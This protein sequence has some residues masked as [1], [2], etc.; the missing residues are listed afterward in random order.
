MS[1]NVTRGE[2]QT[3]RQVALA[4]GFISTPITDPVYLPKI[5]QPLR[6]VSIGL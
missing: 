4:F 5:A 1:L 6:T 3:V 2:G